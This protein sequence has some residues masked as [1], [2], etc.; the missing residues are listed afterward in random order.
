MNAFYTRL[1]IAF[2]LIHKKVTKFVSYFTNFV[3]NLPKAQSPAGS[4][5]KQNQHIRL[6]SFVCIYDQSMAYI[7]QKII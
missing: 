6:S 1:Q 4:R 5:S 7:L 2:C 3:K